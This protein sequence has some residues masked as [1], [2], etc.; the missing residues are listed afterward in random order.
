MFREQHNRKKGSAHLSLATVCMTIIFTHSV[1]GLRFLRFR[2]HP[3]H[4]S[5]KLQATVGTHVVE[6][7]VGARG[8]GKVRVW[9]AARLAMTEDSFV[10]DQLASLPDLKLKAPK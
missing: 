7:T 3:T 1:S 8:G 6:R 4:E 10:R 5:G 9:R 2:E